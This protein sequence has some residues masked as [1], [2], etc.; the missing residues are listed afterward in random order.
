MSVDDFFAVR[1]KF[2]RERAGVTIYHLAQ[3][4]PVSAPNI[5]SIEKSRRLPSIKNIEEFSKVAELKLGFTAMANWRSIAKL[6]TEQ[7]KIGGDF[8]PVDEPQRDSSYDY[9]NDYLDANFFAFIE[10]EKIDLEYKCQ[11]SFLSVE[12]IKLLLDEKTVRFQ[13][14]YHHDFMVKLGFTEGQIAILEAAQDNLAQA[15]SNLFEKR[16][17]PFDFVSL[18]NHDQLY[19]IALARYLAVEPSSAIKLLFSIPAKKV[20]EFIKKNL[21]TDPHQP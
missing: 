18:T 6:H 7:I 1:F 8:C 11:E 10:L 5:V 13:I 4:T 15:H 19:I 3:V 12:H 14:P 17:V 20:S 21:K 16:R 2:W 9:K